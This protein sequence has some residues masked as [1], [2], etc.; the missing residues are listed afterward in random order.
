MSVL[1]GIKSRCHEALRD[2]KQTARR[3]EEAATAPSPAIM[4]EALKAAV[5]RVTPQIRVMLRSKFAAAGLK[6]GDGKHG[7]HLYDQISQAKVD[8]LFKG[9]RASLSISM[10]DGLSDKAYAKAASLNY[11]SVRQPQM[12]RA[13]VDL[14]TQ[15]AKIQKSGMIG[16][17][18]KKT[19]KQ[20][21]LGQ[22]AQSHR[23]DVWRAGRMNR[24]RFHEVYYDSR[25]ASKRAS[26]SFAVT[27]MAV[28]RSND[29]KGGQLVQHNDSVSGTIS[30]IPPK[31]FFTFTASERQLIGKMIEA[32]VLASLQR[33]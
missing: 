31:P 21:V 33:S 1:A 16:E 3:A 26:G 14:P 9:A 7:G 23:A 15:T 10:P 12:M 11:G 29:V 25:R 32:E 30:V 13:V 22:K 20:Q 5:A 19:L 8:L 17:K 6:R 2:L 27:A 28:A 18:A 4:R 24:A